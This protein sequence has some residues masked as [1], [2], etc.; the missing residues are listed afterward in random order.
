MLTGSQN[1]ISSF[2]LFDDDT[3]TFTIFQKEW[4]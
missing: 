3:L 1:G 2:F 4:S